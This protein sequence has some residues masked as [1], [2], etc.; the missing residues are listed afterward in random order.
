[1]RHTF[2]SSLSPD[3]SAIA[4]IVRDG[5]YPHAVQAQLTESG[6][7][8]E[9][10]VELPVDGP[11]TRVLHSPDNKWIACEVSPRGTERLETW[12][13]STDPN[14]PGATQ[15]QVPGDAKTTLVEWDG[16]CL[17]MDAVGEDGVA[18]AR[19]VSPSDGQHRVLDRRSDSVLVAA[20]EG[21]ALV[22]V[23]P[24]GNRELLLVR[25]DGSWL[26][27]LPP[28]PGAT[29]ETGRIVDV[30]TPHDPHSDVTI[31]LCSDHGSDRQRLLRIDVAGNREALV[32]TEE[33]ISNPESDVDEFVISEDG[34]TAA[35]LWNVGGVSSLELLTLGAAHRVMV[36]RTV[37][38]PGMVAS[39]LS[40]TDNGLLLSLTVEGPNLPPTVEVLRTDTGRVE[41]L[42]S[43]R[44]EAIA[45][46]AESSHV[47]ELVH[48]T[49]RDGV[50]LS[51]WLYHGTRQDSSTSEGAAYIHLHGGPELQ[52]R[53]VNH[54]VLME[55]VDA[56]MTV[57][58]PN[59][60]GSLGAGRAFT[61]ADE[62]YGRFAAIRDVADSAR[63]LVDTGLCSASRIA[64]GGRSYGGY[65]SLLAAAHYPSRFAAIVDACGMTS[66]DTYFAST[67]PWLA[68]AAYPKYGNP[69][70]DG[71]LLK[72][73][74]PLNHASK[75]STP[76]LFMHGQWDTNVPP[77]E[78]KQM[79]RAIQAAGTPTELVIIPGEG[80]KF[81]KPKSRRLI[82]DAMLDFFAGLGLITK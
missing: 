37:D 19:V 23:G 82:A 18:E 42:N 69:L 66:F 41:P 52:S 70:Q 36:R 17:A 59:I 56:G 43:A 79:H 1:M 78:S 35:V 40:I 25:P 20:E 51:G 7:A 54:D 50:E 80:H 32:S 62:R 71:E 64:V 48:F 72:E 74:S 77:T 24:R 9:R 57:F 63:F 44:S 34:S 55:L 5:G 45:A 65:L 39:N 73:I 21:F 10:P 14:I 28:E 53:P 49:A 3:G 22:R 26:P 30:A 6:M 16:N 38:V 75:I 8:P 15:L 68:S 4:Y 81:V 27:L 46:R 29:T 13:V 2:G 60:R 67:E 76:V 58:T 31:V 61:H 11:V 33:L 47:P 12:T